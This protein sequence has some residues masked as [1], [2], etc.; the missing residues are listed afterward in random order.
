M[1]TVPNQ[2]DINRV[3]A[4]LDNPPTGLRAMGL[5][6]S[7]LNNGARFDIPLPT[8]NGS[9]ANMSVS[10]FASSGGN[11]NGFKN[12]QLFYSTDGGGT[13]ISGPGAVLTGAPQLINLAVPA[14]A[15]N[16]PLLVLRLVFTNGGTGNDLQTLIDNIQVNGTIFPS[17]STAIAGRGITSLGPLSDPRLQ[18]LRLTLETGALLSPCF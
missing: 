15:N 7:A 12:V 2:I 14:G 10:F 17:Q 11:G 1:T 16:A 4:D 9:F 13:F 6:R 3:P 18:L 5:R 8:S